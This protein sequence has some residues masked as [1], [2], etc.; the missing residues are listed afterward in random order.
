MRQI[1]TSAKHFFLR[2]LYRPIV[3]SLA[4]AFF[5]FPNAAISD[6]SVGPSLKNQVR[7]GSFNIEKLGKNNAYQAQNAAII[8]KNYDI[9]AIQEVMNTGATAKNPI[10]T[11]GIEALKRI[12]ASLGSDWD[13]VVSPTPNGTLSAEGSRAF[14]TFEYYAF[15]YRKSKLEL[16]PNSAHLWDEAKNPIQGLKDQKRQFDRQPFIASFKA[17]GGNLDFTLV[18]IHAAAPA[19][20]WRRDEVK[21]LKV[22]Y[23]KVQDE[24]SKQN[25]VFLLGDF[26]T[27]VDKAEWDNLKSIPTMKHI[28]TSKDITTLNK[29]TGE[30]SDSQYDTIWYQGK[31]SDEDIISDSAQVDQAW[32]DSLKFPN[33]KPTTDIEGRNSKLI[34]FYGKYASD[35]LPVTVLLWADRDADN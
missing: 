4:A 34:W 23:E 31:Y 30:L 18:T 12:V 13:Y 35:H 26:N 16:I 17:K 10:G 5:F 1:T 19:A 14:N 27:N 9:V 28:L 25:D 6:D 33:V 11:K 20:K 29:T 15:I 21:R 32:K 24:D 2:C 7:L 8:L 22:L 3:L